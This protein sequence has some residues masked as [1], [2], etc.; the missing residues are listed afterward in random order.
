MTITTEDRVALLREGITAQAFHVDE[1][2]TR[3]Y[4]ASPEDAAANCAVPPGRR[5][6]RSLRRGAP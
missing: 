6:G 1:F 3:L 5:D 2:G 4:V